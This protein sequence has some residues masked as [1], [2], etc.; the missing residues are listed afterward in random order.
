MWCTHADTHRG[1]EETS[2]LL[3]VTSRCCTQLFAA[4]LPVLRRSEPRPCVRNFFWLF[5]QQELNCSHQDCEAQGTQDP[6][7]SKCEGSKHLWEDLDRTERC[8]KK[9][10]KSKNQVT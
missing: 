10:A 7:L 9:T 5:A 8:N 3:R 6:A 2:Q 4:Q 1:K